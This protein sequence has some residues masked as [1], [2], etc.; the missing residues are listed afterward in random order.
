MSVKM[1]NKYK[2]NNGMNE[3]GASSEGLLPG[4]CPIGDQD[5]PG[6]HRT[7][8]DRTTTRIKRS[9]EENRVAMQCYFR[10]EYGRNGYR[11]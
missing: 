10:S 4:R 11:N 2:P 8:A 7:T 9:Q 1:S 6:L 3:A 5:G